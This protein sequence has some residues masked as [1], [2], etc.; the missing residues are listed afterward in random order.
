MSSR[1]NTLADSLSPATESPQR[2]WG[3]LTGWIACRD[4]SGGLWVDFPGNKTGPVSARLA[5]V[6]DAQTL[7]AAVS[8]HQK[9]VLLF[10]QGD[11]TRPFI[12]GL[13]Q[14]PSPSPLVDE[15][16]EA[17]AQP[18]AS[19]PTEAKVDGRR[20]LI[21][22]K[23]EI[24]LQCGEASITLRRNGKVIV[25]GTYLESRATGTHRIKGGSV[26]IN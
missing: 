18:S 15:L 3:S 1:A 6:I 14:D 17:Q 19:R 5:T 4:D 16:L 23:D 11:P 12:M 26:E 2:L 10:E 22:G 24:V 9:V 7:Q 20:V 13:I 25:K 8:H 21:E